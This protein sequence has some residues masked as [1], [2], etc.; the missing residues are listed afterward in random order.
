LM[1]G[2]PILCGINGSF[3]NLIRQLEASAESA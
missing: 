3:N 1:A 2:H